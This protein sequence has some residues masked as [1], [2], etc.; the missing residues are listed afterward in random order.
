[1]DVFSVFSISFRMFWKLLGLMYR[2]LMRSSA[3]TVLCA[4][5]PVITWTFKPKQ[6]LVLV[7]ILQHRWHPTTN[8]QLWRKSSF[9]AQ[10]AE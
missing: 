3:W 5:L 9:T 6:C 2:S 8:S 10:V 7:P 1:M 4:R